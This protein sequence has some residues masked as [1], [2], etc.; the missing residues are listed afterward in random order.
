MPIE[1]TGITTGSWLDCRKLTAAGELH[2]RFQS[3]GL[4]S[5]NETDAAGIYWTGSRFRRH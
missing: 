5:I 3:L 1:T 2:K 4:A